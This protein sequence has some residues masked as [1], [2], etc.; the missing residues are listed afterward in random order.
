MITLIARA[1]TDDWEAVDELEQIAKADPA[2][3]RPHLREL[4]DRGLLWP[5]VLFAAA[6]EE[7]VHEV[8]TRIDRGDER[9]VT[10]C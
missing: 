3:L 7:T 10:Y 8:I 4:L 2:V 6:D 9:L 1:A 5:S